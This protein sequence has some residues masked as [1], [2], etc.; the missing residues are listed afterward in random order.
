MIFFDQFRK[1]RLRKKTMQTIPRDVWNVIASKIAPPNEWV[2]YKKPRS[3]HE[4]L[5][6]KTFLANDLEQLVFHL[7][8]SNFK[9][10]LRTLFYHCAQVEGW[11]TKENFEVH[12]RQGDFT[13]EDMYSIL[14]REGFSIAQRGD[15]RATVIPPVNH[16]EESH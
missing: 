8:R 4:K 16:P 1:A 15:A 14:D 5:V 11:T 9:D 13:F 7:F 6:V 10:L 3:W 2:V 12:Y